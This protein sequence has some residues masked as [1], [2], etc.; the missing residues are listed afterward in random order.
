MATKPMAFRLDGIMIGHIQ[1]AIAKTGVETNLTSLLQVH[2]VNMGK[3]LK[4]AKTLK[5]KEEILYSY[6]NYKL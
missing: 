4:N 2:V 5:E 1:E 3:Q 6:L